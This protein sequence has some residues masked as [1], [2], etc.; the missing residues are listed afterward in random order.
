MASSSLI[1]ALFFLQIIPLIL[2]PPSTLAGGLPV[3]AVSAIAMAALGFM[4][5]RGRAW[6][7]T[8]SIF[9][10]GFNAIIRIMMFFPHAVSVSTGTAFTDWPYII[11]SVI[12]VALS[13]W[14]L[15]RLDRTDVRLLVG[16]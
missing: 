3:I 13:I 6:A 12:S 9:I 8:M 5:I 10:Q 7:L 15:Y 1:R 14:F 11:T 2:Y 4:A 16:A